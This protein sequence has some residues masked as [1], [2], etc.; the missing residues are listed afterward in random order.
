MSTPPTP[1]PIIVN[2]YG[3]EASARAS[4]KSCWIRGKTTL[5]E[6]MPDPPIVM[7]SSDTPSRSHA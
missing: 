2:V 3:I 7:S 5:T 6:Y 4:P 1:K